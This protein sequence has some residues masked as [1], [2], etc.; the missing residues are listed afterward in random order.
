MVM[1]RSPVTSNLATTAGLLFGPANKV[2]NPMGCDEG[3]MGNDEVS[4][5]AST[6][7][8]PNGLGGYTTLSSPVKHVFVV[9]D[10]AALNE[11]MIG[12]CFPVAFGV[13]TTNVSD[14]SGLNCVDLPV[15]NLGANAKTGAN[16]PTMA[17]DAA[18]NLYTVWEVAP[19]NAIRSGDRRYRLAIQL[20]NRPGEHMVGANNDR[21]FRIAGRHVAH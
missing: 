1:Y 17:I 12:R 19:I 8:Q 21:H 14:P 13:P 3:I 16:F 11:I 18:G 6:L 9:H 4:P 15:A 10:N 20:L 7:G 2:S 5:I